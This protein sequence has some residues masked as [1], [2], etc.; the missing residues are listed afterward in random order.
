MDPLAT[1]NLD[2]AA[3]TTT[4]TEKKPPNSNHLI[5]VTLNV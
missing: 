3:A 1:G 4:T 2:F 5:D